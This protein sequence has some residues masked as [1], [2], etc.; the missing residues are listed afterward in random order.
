MKQHVTELPGFGTFD[1]I[2]SRLELPW[3]TERLCPLGI[4]CLLPGD[5]ELDQEADLNVDFG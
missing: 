3:V 4:A 5:G 1:V 2:D